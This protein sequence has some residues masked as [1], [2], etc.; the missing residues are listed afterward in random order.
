MSEFPCT[1]SKPLND[2]G[3]F[4]GTL[5]TRATSLLD[6][7]NQ[8]W[9]GG[10]RVAVENYL[11]EDE[12]LH[13]DPEAVL[14]LIYNEV[15]LR[16]E[17]GESP[18]LDEYSLRFPHLEDR[19]RL[20]FE[21]HRA[22][23][24]GAVLAEMSGVEEPGQGETSLPTLDGYEVLGELGRGAMGVVYKARQ[25]ALDRLVAVKMILAGPHAGPRERARFLTEGKAV[26]RLQHP[27][28]V[29]IHEVGEQDGRPFF[30]LELIRGGSLAQKLS[31]RP[32]PPRSAAELVERLARAV[33][34]A[35]G[36]QIVHRDLKPANVLLAPSD[37][38]RGL[39]LGRPEEAAWF[40]PKITDF[41]LARL[42]DR[43]ARDSAT[44]YPT[45]GPVG[46]P[47]YMAPEQA[48]GPGGDYA[49]VGP[50]RCATD[51]YALGAILYETLT[52]R[53]PF[54]A[55][56]VLE[57]LE[58]VRALDPVPPRRL[59][60]AVPRDLETI[61]LACL[62]KEPQRRYATAL[63]LAEDLRRFLDGRPI[64]QRPAAFW[65][66]ALKW[67]R[68][69]P[70]VAAWL[71]FGV[72]ALVGLA[73]AGLYYVEHRQEWA[74][75]RALDRYQEFVWH[76]DEALFQGTLRRGVDLMSLDEAAAS[77]DATQDAARQALALVGVALDRPG[78]AVLGPHLRAAEKD[79]ITDGCYELLIVLAGAVAAPRPGQQT[80]D[81]QEQVGEALRI[82]ERT[83]QIRGPTRAYHLIRE[84][85]LSQRG[86]QAGAL[87]ERSKAQ[88]LGPASASDYYLSGVQQDRNGNRSEAVRWARAA[89]RLRPNHFEAQ[90]FL[91]MCA[92]DA[93]R[94]GE[95]HLGL[96]S[97]IGQR[98]RFAWTYL[99]RGQACVQQG[100]FPEAEADFAAALEL[101]PRMAVRYAVHV[102]R[103]VLWYRHA[104]LAQAVADLDEAIR[105]Q[106]SWLQGHVILAQAYQKQQKWEEA[107][108]E[109][110]T[111]VRLAPQQPAVYRTRAHFHRDQNELAAALSDFHRAISLEQ[112]SNTALLADDHIECGR[113]H[114]Q[115][116]RPLDALQAFDAALRVRPD[117][118]RAVRLRGL[119]L[120]A[121][122]RY[123]EAERL[124][125]R[126]I[127]LGERPPEVYRGRG[128]ARVR[129]GQFA[130]AIED[131]TQ[132]LRTKR[133]ADVLQHRGWA[134]FFTDAWKL[135][136]GDF[137]EALRLDPRHGDAQVG[138]GL[139][140]VMLGDYRRAVA[141]AEEVLRRK[142]PAT[143]EM[144]HNLACLFAQAAARVKADAR[145]QQRA[146]LEVVYCRQAVKLLG[147]ALLLLPRERRRA[148][149]QEQMRPD[150]ALD[151]IRNSDDFFQ[152]DQQV[153]REYSQPGK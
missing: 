5:R 52:G 15:R 94:A 130:G 3:P 151:P 124:F 105:L 89:L 93:G 16:E 101:D 29:Q 23:Q 100:S 56:T 116:G 22:M 27:G 12:S 149:W 129:L 14:D 42:L 99:L 74:R 91:A 119:T 96:T 145:Q 92:L 122:H 76:R 38:S 106:P 54:I 142:K 115:Q 63:D 104:K 64:R 111:A 13:D 103:G 128:F 57:T 43:D 68:R 34:H 60:P 1:A 148:F 40:E 21:V 127:E 73:A 147:Q 84:H 28:I 117:Y 59:Q 112:P 98:P 19:L 51:V 136:Q 30:C 150:T 62:R 118:P 47:P 25:V 48:G 18:A 114:N 110:D 109:L 55:A 152:F 134:Y 50:G 75:Q 139:A 125:A 67:A 82:L 140:R 10:E 65:E 121:L 77:A 6:D 32:L 46:T 97:C 70:A 87:A 88:A 53:P 144:M 83:V 17:A 69:R 138:R 41:G 108:R 85:L 146:D 44:G 102:N 123:Q 81:L 95:A 135:A 2:A 131:Y 9:L 61:C 141:D 8:R 7:Q 4:R 78:E 45:E 58:Q 66:P 126:S 11:A 71:V 37:A 113:I 80:A 35:H 107:A 143:P 120:M 132:A 137:D 90:C 33:H 20:Q 79:E 86:D 72:A 24:T 39:L 49:K 26:A 31:G 36:E 133:N 153:K